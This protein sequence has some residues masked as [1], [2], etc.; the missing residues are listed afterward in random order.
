MLEPCLVWYKSLSTAFRD[1]SLP[2]LSEVFLFVGLLP[3]RAEATRKRGG[4]GC[5]WEKEFRIT[6][7]CLNKDPTLVGEHGLRMH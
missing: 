7:I 1:A 5:V 3:K 2:E 4:R 6:P